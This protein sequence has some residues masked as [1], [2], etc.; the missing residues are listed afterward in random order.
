MKKEKIKFKV[1]L[2]EMI[3]L[4][5]SVSG[6]YG[7]RKDSL[8]KKCGLS[9]DE[10]DAISEAMEFI[11]QK[12]KGLIPHDVYYYSKDLGQVSFKNKEFGL[13]FGEIELSKT[14]DDR[15]E[16]FIKPKE[17]AALRDALELGMMMVSD[18]GESAKIIKDRVV[19]INLLKKLD[20]IY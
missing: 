17:L 7:Y 3:V 15:I 12:I 8:K 5:S 13:S 19:A 2:I 10:I 14:E 18:P 4:R 20:A 11:F 6:L 1:S 9:E 16:L